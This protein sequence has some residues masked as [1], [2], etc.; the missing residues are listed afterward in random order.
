MSGI[1][2]KLDGGQLDLKSVKKDGTF[3]GYL[4]VFG[5]KDQ[6]RDIVMPGAFTKSLTEHKKKGTM[7]KLLWQH[8]P[9]SPIGIW[10][11][12]KE[13]NH[14]LKGTGELLLDIPQAK[15]VHSLLRAKAVDGISIGYRTVDSDDREDGGRDLKELE[16]WE[17][18]VVT[19]PML[20]EAT[21]TDVKNLDSIRDVERALRDAGVP[22]SFAKLVAQHGY[23]EAKS[24]LEG[25]QRDAETDGE[26]E[27]K[28]KRLL[29]SIN[30]MKGKLHG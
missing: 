12:L 1:E 9:N 18:S 29:N 23:D 5:V 15:Q 8:N 22:N 11:D 13:D 25:Q 24:I 21:V 6:G 28:A 10:T 4:S 7:P 30:S 17:A 16:L 20:K 19:F 14:G 27:E 3:S 26:I 2:N